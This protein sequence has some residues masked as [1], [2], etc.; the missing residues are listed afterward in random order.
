M[1]LFFPPKW[2]IGDK[3]PTGLVLGLEGRRDARAEQGTLF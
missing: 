2:G 3:L 1:K